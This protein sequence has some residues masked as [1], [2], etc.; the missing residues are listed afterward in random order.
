MSCSVLTYRA[1][2]TMIKAF[3]ISLP[4]A[5]ARRTSMTA[6][7][8]GNIDYEIVD[9][10]A[11]R[12]LAG[13]E[14]EFCKDLYCARAFR[15]MSLNELACSIDHMMALERFLA[16]DAD[17]GLILEDDVH[18]KPPDFA[19][20][21]ALV[22]TMPAFDLL[23]VGGYLGGLDYGKVLYRLDGVSVVAVLSPSVC[24][25]GYVVTRRG[26][27]KLASTILPV[28]EPYDAF[29]RNVHDH[30][31]I[32]FETSPWLVLASADAAE[33]Y[34]GGTR[35]PRRSSLSIR[36]TLRSAAFRLRYNVM[37]RV[38][39]LRRF[40]LSYVTRSGFRRLPE[41]TI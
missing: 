28:R 25:H 22:D 14:R 19:R 13:R 24:A 12:A 29:L 30:G 41:A 39:N 34:I 37:R 17:H 32:I 35:Q 31:C 27:R 11:G 3:V 20:I 9:A 2:A 1:P 33:S 36:K 18:I 4:A 38:F 23:K 8:D 10:V 16:S 40:G 26:A 15:D 5:H 7:L 21:S 6:M